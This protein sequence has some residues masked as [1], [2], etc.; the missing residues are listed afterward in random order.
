MIKNH[1]INGI[2]IFFLVFLVL[3]VINSSPISQLP[4]Q[5]THQHF[6]VHL[7]M[8]INLP[9]SWTKHTPTFHCTLINAHKVWSM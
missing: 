9:T 2:G 5:N 6:I 3:N 1:K 8:L 4:G 7:L